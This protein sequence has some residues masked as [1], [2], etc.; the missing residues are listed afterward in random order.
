[1][2]QEFELADF[3]IRFLRTQ[4]LDGFSL[5]F[6]PHRGRHGRRAK[7]GTVVIQATKPENQPQ[8]KGSSTVEDLVERFHTLAKQT[9]E[10]TE[11]GPDCYKVRLFDHMGRPVEDS[12][13]LS[14][15]RN[16]QSDLKEK[17]LLKAQKT[18]LATL[19][20]FERNLETKD[21]SFLVKSVL[22]ERYAN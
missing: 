3:T 11:L 6:K 9:R 8:L 20:E 15:L 12:E 19:K 2:T 4:G 14:D 13:R 17:Y 16:L 7:R 21:I 22:R 5:A 1:M 18:L 10:W